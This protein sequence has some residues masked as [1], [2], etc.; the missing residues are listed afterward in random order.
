CLAAFVCV[1]VLINSRWGRS[2]DELV[3]DWF[4]H[5]WHRLRIHIV[6]AIFRF[7]VDLFHQILETIERLLYTVD[8]LLRFRSGERSAMTAIKTVLGVGWSV[9][10]Y[11]IR[12]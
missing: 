9:V 8:E 2:V 5:V 6:A 10:N 3:T 4:A 7:V 12:F 11:V 1:N